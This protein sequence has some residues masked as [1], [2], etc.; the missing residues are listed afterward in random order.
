LCAA[1][2]WHVRDF[3]ARTGIACHLDVPADSQVIDPDS[4][5]AAYRILQESLTN[6]LRHAKAT[7][8]DILL[9]QEEDNVVLRVQDNG[10]GAAADVLGSPAAIGLA[11]MRERTMLVGG[12]F[13]F[14]S[15]VGSGTAV[16]V[17]LPRSKSQNPPED[18][19]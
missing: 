16:E 2:E 15:L 13:E 5:T 3:Q 12:Q 14:S 6:V 1:V 8:V 7:R 11:G 10:C 17:R 18:T 19:A 4:A 9:R